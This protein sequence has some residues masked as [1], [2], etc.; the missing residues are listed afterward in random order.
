MKALGEMSFQDLLLWRR[1][2]DENIDHFSKPELMEK[3]Q[4]KLD[5]WQSAGTKVED[6]IYKR[7]KFLFGDPNKR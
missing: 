6:E 3:Y 4:D 7:E 2:V 1:E 5:Y